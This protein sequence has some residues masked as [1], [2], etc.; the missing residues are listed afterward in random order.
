MK[1]YFGKYPKTLPC[2][3]LEK[4]DFITAVRQGISE[5]DRGEH[6]SID[7]V[8]RELPAWIIK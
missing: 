2:M 7:D 4:I 6:I 3:R 1:T 5:L 8:E